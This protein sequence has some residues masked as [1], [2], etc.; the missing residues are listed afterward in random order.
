VSLFIGIFRM[1]SKEQGYRRLMP[2]FSMNRLQRRD[3]LGD[4]YDSTAH[5]VVL[6][7]NNAFDTCAIEAL[8]DPVA[9]GKELSHHHWLLTTDASEGS[10]APFVDKKP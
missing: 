4:L 1:G 7:T 6:V 3:G 5:S 10:G 2:R 8:I 9:I